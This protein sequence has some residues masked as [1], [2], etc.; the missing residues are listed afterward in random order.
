MNSKRVITTVSF[1]PEKRKIIN[2]R[3]LSKNATLINECRGR[4][5]I[6]LRVI[7]KKEIRCGL[8]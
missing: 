5:L 4:R 6:T 1:C 3:D 8:F 7:K 2:R